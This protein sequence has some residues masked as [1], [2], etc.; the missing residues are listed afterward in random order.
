MNHLLN[1]LVG[2]LT[3][4]LLAGVIFAVIYC[5]AV[6]IFVALGM[7][8]FFIG[9]VVRGMWQGVPPGKHEDHF[10]N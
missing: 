2:L 10:S 3:I 5:P 7:S 9:V 4:I 8:S 6:F 1:F